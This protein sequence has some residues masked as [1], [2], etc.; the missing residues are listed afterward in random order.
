MA[1]SKAKVASFNFMSAERAVFCEC[2]RVSKWRNI[3][4]VAS[5]VVSRKERGV[6]V[7]DTQG[8]AW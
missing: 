6:F 7:G 8:K 4:S 3:G 1:T 2:V 5:G